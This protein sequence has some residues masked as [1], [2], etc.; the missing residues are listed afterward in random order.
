MSNPYQPPDAQYDMQSGFPPQRSG[1]GLGIAALVCG[2]LAIVMSF[3]CGIFGVPLS[4]AAII[5]GALGLKSSARGMAI[6]GL[7]CGV[8]GL[9]IAVGVVAIGIAMH[10]NDL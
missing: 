6:A 3:C 8:I 10:L 4:I 5:T 9:L 1:E 2:V 7:V